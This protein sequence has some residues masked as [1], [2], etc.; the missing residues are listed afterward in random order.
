MDKIAEAITLAE[1]LQDRIESHDMW[2][3]DL[4]QSVVNAWRIEILD[5]ARGLADKCSNLLPI[6]GMDY[7]QA[8]PQRTD[9]VL[10]LLKAYRKLKA[11]AA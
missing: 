6:P 11:L 3:D 4:D 7:H 2:C 10:S 8:L 1:R 5:L 9:E